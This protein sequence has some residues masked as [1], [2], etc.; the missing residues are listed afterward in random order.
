MERCNNYRYK[1]D[2]INQKSLLVS[3]GGVSRL[4]KRLQ[5]KGLIK[6]V[7]NTYRYYMT[8]LGRKTVNTALKIKELFIIQNLDYA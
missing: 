3:T 7:G 8:T 1:F 2:K 5:V 6:K 4:L